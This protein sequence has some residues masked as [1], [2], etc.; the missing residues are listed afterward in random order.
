MDLARSSRG[1]HHLRKAQHQQLKLKKN[2]LS[3]PLSDNFIILNTTVG[4]DRKIKDNQQTSFF[5]R[6]RPNR[7]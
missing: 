6:Q 4:Q 7:L 2:L 1:E 3:Q 5:Y